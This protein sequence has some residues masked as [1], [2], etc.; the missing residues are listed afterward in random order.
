MYAEKRVVFPWFTFLRFLFP[1]LFVDSDYFSW[2]FI[3][4]IFLSNFRSEIFEIFYS[5]FRILLEIISKKREKKREISYIYKVVKNRAE[6][7]F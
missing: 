1:R 2:S 7:F 6:R 5:K 3:I 4:I